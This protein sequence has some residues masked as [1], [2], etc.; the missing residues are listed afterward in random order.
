MNLKT[1]GKIT[2]VGN[3]LAAL[4]LCQVGAAS[5]EDLVFKGEFALP[6]TKEAVS[7]VMTLRDTGPLTRQMKL[8]YND[9]NT[10]KQIPKFDVELTQQLHILATNSSL[11][12]LI[13]QHVE[14]ADSN[15]VFR[16]TFKFP[17][18]GLY[19]IY[20]DA[21]PTG[22]GQQ[23]VRFDVKVGD[24]ASAASAPAGSQTTPS[25]TRTVSSS[26]DGYTVKLDVA[27]L[28]AQ[29]DSA[30]KISVEK[31]GKPA[32]D[33]TPYLGVAA[34]AVFVR[35]DDLAY[36]H[37][38]AVGADQEAS[39]HGGGHHDATDEA[40]AH[41]HGKDAAGNSHGDHMNENNHSSHSAPHHDGTSDHAAAHAGHGDTASD[42]PISPDMNLF[43]TPPAPG[44]YALWIEFMGGGQVHT[45]PFQLE[46]Q[47][48][49]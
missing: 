17:A 6:N 43:V 32:D 46:I 38:H 12:T 35:A 8:V 45:I 4:Y 5:A 16:T 27:E 1:S 21:V 28:R 18:P 41:G 26:K 36:V 29:Q 10:G 14:S 34:H 22:Y 33:I 2:A 24:E 44:R 25:T 49:T 3:V 20:T 30:V 11:S 19:H 37:A 47:P 42:T 9:K 13:H 48:R 23:V 40:P 7:G 15:G 39:G 31:N